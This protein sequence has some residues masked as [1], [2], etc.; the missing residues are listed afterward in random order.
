MSDCSRPKQVVACLKAL[1][2]ALASRRSARHSPGKYTAGVSATLRG[3]DAR[4]CHPGTGVTSRRCC[5][6]ILPRGCRAKRGGRRQR[7]STT[8]IPSGRSQLVQSVQRGAEKGHLIG[9]DLDRDI[10]KQGGKPAFVGERT[11]EATRVEW[12]QDPRWNSTG[13]IDPAGRHDLE[14]QVARLGTQAG[15]EDVQH[16]M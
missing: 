10:T 5:L 15:Y 3:L 4:L 11:H 1:D 8:K 14:G 9:D 13:K 12:R 16:R 6:T 2:E 7:A